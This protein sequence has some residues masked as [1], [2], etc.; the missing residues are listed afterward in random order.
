[1]AETIG[2]DPHDD[3]TQWIGNLPKAGDDSP[4]RSTECDT[5][6]TKQSD[7]QRKELPMEEGQQD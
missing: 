4:K 3:S 1:M 2:D 6:G 7:V 5:G